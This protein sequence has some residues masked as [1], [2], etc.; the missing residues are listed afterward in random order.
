MSNLPPAVAIE[1]HFFADDGR[2]PNNPSLPLIVAE[3]IDGGACGLKDQR[4]W[5]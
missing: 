1:E 3:A 5:K 4:T 2:V